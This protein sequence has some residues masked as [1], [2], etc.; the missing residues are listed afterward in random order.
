MVAAQGDACRITAEPDELR[1]RARP[2]REA[3]CPYVQRLEQV[4]LPGT[5]WA[6][7]QDKPR[8]E[9]Q[10][11]LRVGTKIAK[12]E[13]GDDQPATKAPLAVPASGRSGFAGASV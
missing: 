12:R 5:V 13:C 3:L 7:D 11:E 9:P 6:G 8:L 10:I 2:R 4:G 1:I